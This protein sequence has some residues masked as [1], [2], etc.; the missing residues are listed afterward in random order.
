[1]NLDEL[2]PLWKS[3]QKQ[4]EEHDEWS[5]AQLSVLLKEHTTGTVWYHSSSRVF[6]NVC[7]SLLLIGMNGC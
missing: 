3:Y 2:K 6:L 5:K 7:V 1:M 4:V